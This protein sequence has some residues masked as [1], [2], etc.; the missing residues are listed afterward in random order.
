MSCTLLLSR[1]SPSDLTYFTV[2]QY[3]VDVG[4][5]MTEVQRSRFYYAKSRSMIIL[6]TF[7][8]MEEPSDEDVKKWGTF[9]KYVQLTQQLMRKARDSCKIELSTLADQEDPL[10]KRDMM[11]NE[12]ICLALEPL[13]GGKKERKR[14]LANR[15]YFGR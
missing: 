8:R 1:E 2:P 11:V 4:A 14:P 6:P 3:A 13:I 12:A 15:E 9:N 5:T 10:L 7:T